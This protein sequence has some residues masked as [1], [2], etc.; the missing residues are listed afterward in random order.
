GAGACGGD[1]RRRPR[2]RGRCR[3]PPRLRPTVCPS[4][5]CRR[6]RC[7]SP[8][9]AA[10]RGSHRRR[11]AQ[12]PIRHRPTAGDH[13]SDVVKA[14]RAVP[15][16]LRGTDGPG[17][18]GFHRICGPDAGRHRPERFERLQALGN[19]PPPTSLRTQGVK[20]REKSGI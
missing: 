12:H 16:V 17:R 1:S 10:A 4:T 7:A 8:G 6:R 9:G 14:F 20:R 5:C 11:A 13:S 3:R 2:R 15:G 19:K 18:S